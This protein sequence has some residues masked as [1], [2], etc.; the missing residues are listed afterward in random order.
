M[1]DRRRP[2]ARRPPLLTAAV[3]LVALVT[4][5]LGGSALSGCS[6]ASDG[7][8][9]AAPPETAVTAPE[10]FVAL[11]AQETNNSDRRDLQDDWAQIVLAEAIPPGGV[12]VNL[13]TDDATV[14]SALDRQL[15]QAADLHPTIA[16]VWLESADVRR[17]H[18]SGHLRP[19][20]DRAGRGS[21]GGR[22]DEDPAAHAR[23]H[24]A[25]DR[26]PAPAPAWRG[27]WPRWPRP[28]APPW[29]HWATCPTARQDTGQRRIAD[30]VS[31]ALRSP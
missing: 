29:S 17:G 3:V 11:G 23:R 12:Y 28:P 14:Q 31:S 15:P 20:A 19:P 13:A 30:Q 1:P 18:P 27:R 4:V 5:A 7:T 8:S 21:P 16:T 9:S 25:P 10:V 26:A 2:R 24:P 22:G 6:S